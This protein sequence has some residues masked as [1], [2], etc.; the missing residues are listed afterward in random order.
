VTAPTRS[1]RPYVRK[2][3]HVRAQY[4]EVD[5]T[6]PVAKGKVSVSSPALGMQRQDALRW[7]SGC[8]IGVKRQLVD[9]RLISTRRQVGLMNLMLSH[10]RKWHGA[11]L[12]VQI[13]NSTGIL[14]NEEGK[15]YTVRQT[16][17][18]IYCAVTLKEVVAAW[19]AVLAHELN[20]LRCGT[21]VTTRGNLPPCGIGDVRN[22]TE[23][24]P[25]CMSR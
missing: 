18:G 6:I 9:R 14:I 25:L 20:I 11:T 3:F 10:A 15:T 13:V 12:R 21:R 22:R 1:L 5:I 8:K 7:A 4:G 24:T 16:D 19:I 2:A 17:N 23:R